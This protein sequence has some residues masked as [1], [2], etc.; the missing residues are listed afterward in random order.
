MTKR[1]QIIRYIEGLAFKPSA[2]EVAIKV[3]C[4]RQYVYYVAA[5]A[6]LALSD[7]DA[8][9]S[10]DYRHWETPGEELGEFD[11]FFTGLPVVDDADLYYESA[12]GEY[13]LNINTGTDIVGVSTIMLSLQKRSGENQEKED[14][15]YASVV[16]IDLEDLVEVLKDKPEYLRKLDRWS[17]TGKA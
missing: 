11:A 8:P 9:K 13:V 3:D 12:D 10:E 4:S 7:R 2:I 17:G 15:Y 6:G 5:K 1:E 16:E 14:Y